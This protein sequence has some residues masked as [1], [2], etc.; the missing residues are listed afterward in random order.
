M[1]KLD[2]L[3]RQETKR[4]AAPTCRRASAGQG[5]EMGLLV[6]IEHSRTERHGTTNEDTIKAALDERATDPMDS[7]RSEVQS[8][9]DL[10]VGPRWAKGTTIGFEQDASPS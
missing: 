6:A 4:P 2:E 7:D 1:P 9:T 3:V 5:D 10:L 8:I